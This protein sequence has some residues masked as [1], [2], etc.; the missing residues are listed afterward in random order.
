MQKQLA[1]IDEVREDVILQEMK[2]ILLQRVVQR[3]RRCKV[4][5][6]K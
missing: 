3:K 1:Q 6:S 4:R 2:V 5:G